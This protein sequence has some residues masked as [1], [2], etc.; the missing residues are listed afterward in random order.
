MTSVKKG[1]MSNVSE[2]WKHLKFL[3]NV[4]WRA[5]RAAYRNLIR[6]ELKK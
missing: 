2:R 4:F 1:T 3:K 6:T 5:E